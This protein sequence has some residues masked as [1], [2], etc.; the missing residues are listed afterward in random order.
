MVGAV[1]MVY[2]YVNVQVKE[3]VTANAVAKR[4]A[5]GILTIVNSV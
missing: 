3:E 5:K 1:P 4:G 2:T